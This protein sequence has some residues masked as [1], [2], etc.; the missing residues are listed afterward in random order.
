MR[1]EGLDQLKHSMTSSGIEPT[2]F[3]LVAHNLSTGTKFLG[4][5]IIIIDLIEIVW[6]GG[7][8]IHLAQEK[9]N[10]LL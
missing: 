10:G 8:R 6:E 5:D 4:W 3:R 9:S 7:G 1:L 2:I